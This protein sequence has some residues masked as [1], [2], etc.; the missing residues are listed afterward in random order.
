MRYGGKVRSL[1]LDLGT[2]RRKG[3][4]WRERQN[5]A[6]SK[7]SEEA[8]LTKV[9]AVGWRSARGSTRELESQIEQCLSWPQA[10]LALH[11]GKRDT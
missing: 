2:R 8:S 5:T 4:P 1:M 11:G 10:G 6:R 3:I 9:E 7:D